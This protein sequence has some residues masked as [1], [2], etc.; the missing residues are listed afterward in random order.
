MGAVWPRT[1][2]HVMMAAEQRR[3]ARRG[4]T[5]DTVPKNCS[6]FFADRAAD[7]TRVCVSIECSEPGTTGLGHR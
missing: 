1:D 7:N 3:L 5:V 2:L 6:F 4:W